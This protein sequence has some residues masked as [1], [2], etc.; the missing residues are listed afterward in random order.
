MADQRYVYT[1]HATEARG[2][3]MGNIESV[4]NEY[5]SE[6]WR[7]T[8]TLERDGTTIGMVFEREV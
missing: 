1:T 8:E 3:K 2:R 6:G 4:I 7:L 5:A